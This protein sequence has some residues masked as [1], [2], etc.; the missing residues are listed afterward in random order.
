VALA[1]LYGL[2]GSGSP[3][4]AGL[5]LTIAA[6]I[7]VLVA[8]AMICQVSIAIRYSR[9]RSIADRATRGEAS[10]A[11]TPA[12]VEAILIGVRESAV[13]LGA[14]FRPEAAAEFAGAAE[15]QRLHAAFVR[16]TLGSLLIIG[17]AG[18]FLA[19]VQLITGSGL[20]DA[21]STLGSIPHSDSVSPQL[22][23][24]YAGLS[25][26]FTRVY[27]ALGYAFL[28]SLSGLAGTIWL[29]L[30]GS[31]VVQP[32]KGRAL[33]AIQNYAERVYELTA[34]PSQ[35]DELAR[36][37]SAAAEALNTSG[38]AITALHQTSALLHSAAQHFE[39]AEA[40][41]VQLSS[42]LTVLSTEIQTS[43]AKWDILIEALRESKTQ[44][45]A[46]LESFTAEAG[47]QREQTNGVVASAVS[48]MR[49]ITHQMADQIK[50]V[51]AAKMDQ[52]IRIQEELRQVLI[53]TRK[54]WEKAGADVIERTG[55]AFASSLSAVQEVVAQ[56]RNDATA[57]QSEMAKVAAYAAAAVTSHETV[58]AGHAE[59]VTTSLEQWSNAPAALQQT[60]GS[61]DIAITSL[62]AALKRVEVMPEQ[63]E[64]RVLSSVRQLDS[65][66]Q[67]THDRADA[68]S[69]ERAH[70][71]VQRVRAWIGK[72]F[73]GKNGA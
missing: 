63:W 57:A 30:I 56:S 5:P 16:W 28:S 21:L 19:F 65:R 43:Q 41:T 36:S 38:Q 2:A 58:L 53:D 6:F 48:G 11:T 15:S 12:W 25:A 39:K 13:R 33:L 42:T 61:V 14:S 18:T 29:N 54:E 64:K 31:I 35:T 45:R 37:L 68:K 66:L 27:E 49:D 3:G 23:Q 51:S 32:L 34:P 20:L 4:T 72:T 9:L 62:A 60:L 52:F 10:D 55:R 67:Q 17:L 46:V 24:S 22:A 44:N 8:V 26:A 71:P 7:A 1:Q 59:A 70:G 69:Q 73:R 47:R 50:Q 40:A